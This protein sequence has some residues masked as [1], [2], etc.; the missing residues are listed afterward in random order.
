MTSLMYC[1]FLLY[2]LAYKDEMDDAGD[3]GLSVCGIAL[4]LFVH[5]SSTAWSPNELI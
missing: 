3:A 5:C 2:R 4:S 1:S